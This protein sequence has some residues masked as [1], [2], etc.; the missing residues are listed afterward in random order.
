MGGLGKMNLTQ[1]R[2][3]TKTQRIKNFASLHLCAF[4]L[5]FGFLNDYGTEKNISI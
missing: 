4:A 5:K 2:Q 3:E 1:R